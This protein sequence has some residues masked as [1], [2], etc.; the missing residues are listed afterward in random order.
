MEK[1]LKHA[2]SIVIIEGKYENIKGYV[3]NS[4]D[5]RRPRNNKEKE[6]NEVKKESNLFYKIR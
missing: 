3:N 4:S 1:V 2:R 6:S 5:T